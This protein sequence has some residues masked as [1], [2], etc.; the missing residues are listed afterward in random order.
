M[1]KIVNF[2]KELKK[3]ETFL[4]IWFQILYYIAFCRKKKQ[5]HYKIIA[6]FHFLHQS[7]RGNNNNKNEI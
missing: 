3:P 6:V 2:A 5:S 4:T 7:W 1:S